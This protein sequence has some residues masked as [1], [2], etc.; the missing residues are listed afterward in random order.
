MRGRSNLACGCISKTGL[1][2]PFSSKTKQWMIRS[3]R[4]ARHQPRGLHNQ[5]VMLRSESNASLHSRRTNCLQNSP[6]RAVP[7]ASISF[8]VNL[9]LGI[10]AEPLPDFF[11]QLFGCHQLIAE[12]HF[13]IAHDGHYAC[14]ISVCGQ[15]L[16]R[17]TDSLQYSPTTYC[18]HS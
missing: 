2:A 16:R 5:A 9:A 3:P 10:M 14:I 1:G 11:G 4:Y 15:H 8:D 13:S 6:N 18:T 7:G 17:M 12:E